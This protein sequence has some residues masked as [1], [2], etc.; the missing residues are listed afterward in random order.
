MPWWSR[1]RK[2][3]PP[4]RGCRNRRIGCSSTPAS[5]SGTPWPSCPI[6]ET[7]ASHIVMP[8]RTSRRGPAACTATTSSTMPASTPRSAPRTITRPWS[9][10]CT[11]T[12]SA[13][14]STR[15]PT[16]WGSAPTTTPGGTA[17]WKTARPPATALTSTSRGGRR[18]GRSCGTRSCSPSWASPTATSSRPG[19]SG[20]CSPTGPSRSITSTA[21]SP[22]PRTAISRSW[23]IGSMNSNTPW[24]RK[25]PISAS[26]RAF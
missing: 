26:T 20:W 22:W 2:W 5:R 25:T 4:G 8:R 12:V 10:P 11:S 14:S 9:P 19:R 23:A 1:P 24:A 13:K 18:R 3:P 15:C 6:C 21:A 7:W 16:T 17:C